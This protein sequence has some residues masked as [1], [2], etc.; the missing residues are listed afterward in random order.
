MRKGQG[1]DLLKGAAV[2]FVVIGITLTIGQDIMTQ[3]GSNYA[4]NA[5]YEY[6]ATQDTQAGLAELS[7]WFETIGL[8]IAAAVVLGVVGMFIARRL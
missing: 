4:D 8:V 5:S 1:F 2:A 7:S 6:N 3:M